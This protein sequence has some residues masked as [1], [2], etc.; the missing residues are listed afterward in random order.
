MIL[1]PNSMK[2]TVLLNTIQKHV[3]V[4][5]IKNSVYLHPGT[6]GRAGIA[7][8]APAAGREAYDGT[9]ATG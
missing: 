7:G 8:M 1:A 6:T 3:Q 5:Y 4:K 2:V 9:A